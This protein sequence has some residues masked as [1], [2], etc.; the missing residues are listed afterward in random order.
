MRADT[1]GYLTEKNP[2]NP[3]QTWGSFSSHKRKPST[4]DSSFRGSSFT[5][6]SRSDEQES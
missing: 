1:S 2:P 3:Q 4:D 5:L 6:I